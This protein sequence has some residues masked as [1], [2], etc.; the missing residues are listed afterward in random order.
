MEPKIKVGI[1]FANE[2]SVL[3][4]T[5]YLHLSSGK[6]FVGKV[7]V[8]IE[9]ETT[10]LLDEK[11]K[12]PLDLPAVFHPVNPLGGTFDLENVTIGINFHWERQETQKFSGGLEIISETNHLTAINVVPVEDYLASVISSEMSPDSS[13][14]LL[15]A[16]AVVSR[17]WLLAQIEKKQEVMATGK[18]EFATGAEE[19]IVWYD[20]EDHHKF[21]VCADDHCQRYQGITTVTRLQVQKAIE[22]TRGKVLAYNGKICDARYSKCCGGV[23]ELFENAWEPVN[24]PYLTRVADL[25]RTTSENDLDLTQESNACQWIESSPQAF[26][27]TTDAKILKQVLKGYD[28]ETSDFFRWEVTLQQDEVQQLLKTRVNVEVGQ[29]IDLVPVERGV[30]GRLIKLKIIGTD[31]SI[32]IGKELEIR[33]AFSKSH[34]YSSAFVVEKGQIV[35][36]IPASFILRGAGWGHGVGLCQIGAAVMGEKGY[37]YEQILDHYFSGATIENNY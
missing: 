17:G 12:N 20:R 34:L 1:L 23:T 6:E 8:V 29:V 27:N 4:N 30:S 13:E 14:E 9:N 10:Y 22:I 24:H 21:D 11:G 28:Q 2:V 32:I 19:R 35:D 37:K 36:G 31:G 7:K 15:K 25:D 3:F 26:C 18:Q 5:P 33:K 16:H